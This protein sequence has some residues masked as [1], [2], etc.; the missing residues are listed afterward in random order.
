MRRLCWFLFLIALLVLA[1]WVP[2][3]QAVN[4]WDKVFGPLGF[5]PTL[6]VFG[7]VGYLVVRLI[8]A[9]GGRKRS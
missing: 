8:L 3:P 1:L 2:F 6:I 5:A 7:S 9:L 4:S